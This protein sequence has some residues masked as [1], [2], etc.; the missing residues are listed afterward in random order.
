MTWFL[1]EL[2]MKIAN[3]TELQHYLELE[4]LVHI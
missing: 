3:V 1:S 2:N 4:D